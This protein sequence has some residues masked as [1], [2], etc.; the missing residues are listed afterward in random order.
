[1]TEHQRV[2][3]LLGLSRWQEARDSAAS[4]LGED[5]TDAYMHYLLSIAYDGLEQLPRAQDS[6]GTALS[7]DPEQ[8]IYVEQHARLLSLLGQHVDA[9]AAFERALQL[10]PG[11]IE[12]H[13]GYV[14][15]ILRDP[16]SERRLTKKERL[17]TAREI[18]DSLLADAPDTEIAHLI[19]SKVHLANDDIVRSQSAARRA[20]QI[21]PNSA[22]GHQLMG[23]TH[24]QKGDTRAA[25]DSFVAAGKLDPTS[26]T[27]R[28]LLKGLGR[29]KIAL[30]FGAFYLLRI[31]LKAGAR[32]ADGAGVPVGLIVAAIAIL[33]GGFFAARWVTTKRNAEA[34]LS[35][36][37]RRA[38][39]ANR[40]V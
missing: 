23:I 22:I 33:V 1:M 10:D 5:P 15:A 19:D 37:A 28:D 17:A 18:A 7:L 31:T 13:A 20:L 25:G 14:E 39:E 11:S 6:I 30:G 32:G 2:S 12:A 26:S 27:S 29:G 40:G 8:G 16:R 3:Q 4:A 35:P 21:D 38:L 34:A 36:E 9:Q 24:Q